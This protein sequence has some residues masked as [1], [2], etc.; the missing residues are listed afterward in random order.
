MAKKVEA[1]NMV[2]RFAEFKE[3][4]NI[5]KATMISVLEESF[6]NVLAKMFGTDE[7]LDVIMN[8][9][10]GDVQIF[11]N[12]EVVPDG[13]VTD[14]NTQIG[15]TDARADHDPDVEIGEEHTKEIFFADFGRRAILN[16]RQTLQ[17][18]ILD[19]QKENIY[20]KFKE[21]EGEIVTGEVYQTWSKETLLLDDDK[22][23]L[24]LPKSESIPGDYFR[25]GETVRAVISSV[26]NKNN[27]PKITVSRTSDNFLRRLFELEVPE[28]HDGLINIRAVARIPGE[29][30]KI[31]VESYD[32]RID[33][34]GAC[35]GVKGSRIHGIVRELRNENIDVINYTANPTL[36]IQRALSPARISSIR[37][38]EEEKK[39]EVFLRP[40]EV[41]LAIGKGGLNIKLASMLTGYVI[42]VYRDTE[43]AYEEDIYLDEFKDEIEPWVIDALKNIG[44]VTAKSVLNTPRQTL[45]DKADLE[46]ETVDNVLSVLN[47]EFEDEDGAEAEVEAEVSDAEKAADTAATD[48]AKATE[49]KAASEAEAE[50]IDD[51]VADEAE[52]LVE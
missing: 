9:D 33:P 11:Q 38:D 31:A 8:P 4:K 17:S 14:P 1:P 6:R 47:A 24:L 23:E 13:T 52:K 36:F 43:E 18:K 46:E 27:N 51:D 44:C 12:L 32:D 45:I 25:K 20:A 16:L 42:D 41:S 7:N 29:R 40:E 21:L 22:N 3:L 15:L 48:D 19:L 2:E 39:A 50:K 30:A 35:V 37:L 49:A 34:V 28:I 10:K 26:D 5:D